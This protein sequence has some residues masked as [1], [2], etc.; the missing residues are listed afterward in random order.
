MKFRTDPKL[1]FEIRKFG[2]FNTNACYQCGCCTLSCELVHDT[3]SFPRKIMR[4]AIFGLREQLNS[5]TEA[6]VCHDCGD[7]SKVCPRK[8]EPRESMATLRRYLSS[9]YD[10]TGIASRIHSSKAWY[11]SALSFVFILV[12]VL[13]GWYHLKIVEL[14]YSD[15]VTMSMGLEHMF[16]LMKDFTRV[17]ILLPLLILISNAFRMFWFIMHRGEK[18][19]IPFLLYLTEIKSYIIPTVTHKDFEKCE[20]KKRLPKH[21][22]MA[23]G[24]V[25][26]LIIL[27]FFLGWFQTDSIYP[28]YHP[29]RLVGYIITFFLFYG[30]LDILI[31]RIRKKKEIHKFSE[32]GDFAFPVLLFLTALTG[33]AVHIFRYLG[34]ELTTHFTYALHIAVTVPMLII[35]IPFG[36]MSHMIYRPLAI[37]LQAV[38]EKALQIE[39][40]KEPVLKNA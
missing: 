1:L 18:V 36:K 10:W 9:Q 28:I 26:M 32:F 38:K 19:K 34:L 12:L 20:D 14:K 4:S 37:Y 13:V 24:M 16:G 35:E 39:I 21:W 27:V 25:V 5:S 29:Q 31:G 22:V 17:V 15:F 40:K 11:I 7:C 23:F 6:W 2:R 3:I 8:A 30:S 33:I